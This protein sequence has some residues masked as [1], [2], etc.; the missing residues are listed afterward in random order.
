MKTTAI[1]KH[2]ARGIRNDFIVK[3]PRPYGSTPKCYANAPRNYASEASYQKST[4]ATLHGSSE[5]YNSHSA[6]SRIG[7][8]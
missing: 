6:S 1:D 4:E 2:D 7:T 3:H 5:V 8:R